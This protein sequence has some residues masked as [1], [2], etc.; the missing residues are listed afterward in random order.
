MASNRSLIYWLIATL[1]ITSGV[2]ISGQLIQLWTTPPLLVMEMSSTATS[3]AQIYYDRG[4]NFLES[5]SVKL[6]VEASRSFR[7]LRFPLPYKT[8]L[9]L[10]FDPL[11]VAGTVEIRHIRI[12]DSGGRTL[13]EIPPSEIKPFTEIK[14]LRESS[15]TVHIQTQDNATDAAVL[16]PLDK[17]VPLPRPFPSGRIL[18]GLLL[19]NSPILLFALVFTRPGFRARVARSASAV[20][21]RFVLLAHRIGSP[22]FLTFDRV[23]VWFYALCA[24]LFLFNVALD[25]NGSSLDYNTREL[26]QYGPQTVLAGSAKGIRSDEWN[27]VTPDMFYQVFRQH[28]F[29]AKDTPLG[30]SYASLLGNVPVRHITTLCRPQYW[31][32]FVLPPNYA[33]SVFWQM[34]WLMMMT[35]VFTLMLV[36]TGSSWLSIAGALWLFFSACTQWTYSWPSML[37]EMCGLFCFLLVLAMYLT[38]GRNRWMLFLSGVLLAACAVNFAMLAYVPHMLPYVCSGIFLFAGWLYSRRKQILAA[39]GRTQR[40]TAMWVAVL[41]TGVLMGIFCK[42]AAPAIAGIS[43]TEYPG[44][45]SMDGGQLWLPQFASHFFA[46]FEGENRF[47]P[48]ML[49][50]CESSGYMWLAPVTL[51]CWGAMKALSRE[52]KIFLVCLWI[53]ALLLLAWDTLPIP[54]AW[55]H[56]L[57]L[58]KLA[59]QRTLPAMGFLNMAIVI[60]VLSAPEQRRKTSLDVRMLISVPLVL[61]S[62]AIANSLLDGY[63]TWG[64]ILPIAA[65]L[66]LLVGFL[67]DVR[68]KAFLITVLAPSVFFFGLINPVSRGATGIT[69]SQLF[70][71]VEEHKELRQGKWLVMAPESRYGIFAA[72]GLDSYSGMHYLPPVQDFKI[73]NAHGVPT[74]ILNSGGMLVLKPIAPGQKISIESVAGGNV[75]WEVNPMDP[76]VKDLGIRYVAF[77]HEQPA[78]MLAG[79]KPLAELPV[80]GFWLY[81]VAQ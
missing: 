21:R 28:P 55:G 60:L 29:D 43:A 15:G 23:A 10:R 24:V 1:P 61:L 18:L 73:F 2:L 8:I 57:L 12:V 30:A 47:P 53:P 44:R 19:A 16:V 74:K 63:F 34:K 20:D 9:K 79:L 36:L 14:Q 62:L 33:F 45:R 17:P 32:F 5:D 35:G 58:D 6:P 48:S 40:L 26:H 22:D 39:P 77:E 75:Q 70:R 7:E 76:L 13:R 41:L 37:P 46:P 59:A 52:R 27:F 31:G 64:E 4:A 81:E 72:C 71:F 78:A 38:V 56:L 80:S 54:A 67:W 51:L 68:P 65:W 42:D 69:T 49:N 66:A 25:L 11:Q 50:I 3:L